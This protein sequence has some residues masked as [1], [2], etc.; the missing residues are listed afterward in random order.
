M[1]EDENLSK[2][3]RAEISKQLSEIRIEEEEKADEKIK[4]KNRQTFDAMN[5]I[6]S[7]FANAFENLISDFFENEEEAWKNF[8]KELLK[9]LINTIQKMAVAYIAETT[10]KNIAHL[11]LI[12]LAKAAAEI[13]AIEVAAGSL[14]GLLNGFSSGGYT[15]QGR[16]DEPRGVVH[17]GEFVANRYAVANDAVRPV[18]DLIDQAQRN[19]SIANLTT[20]DIAAVARPSAARAHQAAAH[21]VSAP[22]APARDPELAAAIRLLTRT[23]AIAAQAYKEPVHAYTFADGRGGVNEAQELLARMKANASRH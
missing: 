7:G 23:T 16:W 1:L 15:G 21:S 9:T 17:A 5:E 18:L 19:G 20:D 11:G 10:I 14:K 12:G 2:D 6:A 4:E 8:G 22:G 3:A 13:A